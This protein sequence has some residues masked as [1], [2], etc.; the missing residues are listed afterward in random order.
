MPAQKVFN[1]GR[2]VV[3]VLKADHL[4]RRAAGTGEVEK[5]GISR[6][7]GE[8]VYRGVLPNC[9]VRCEPSESRV[10]NVERIGEELRQTVNELRREIR[11]K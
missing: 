10:E 9:F 7:D 2:P 11:V 3:A 6:N 1:L 8:P 5:I 4:W